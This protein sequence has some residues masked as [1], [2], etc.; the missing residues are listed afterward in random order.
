MKHDTY[1]ENGFYYSD[2]TKKHLVGY[3]DHYEFGKEI[4]IP[5]SVKTMSVYALNEFNAP[6]ST[7][8]LPQIKS[9]SPSFSNANI[10]KVVFKE[11]VREIPEKLFMD[12]NVKEVVLPSSLEIIGMQAFLR[13][14]TRKVNLE[15]VKSIEKEAFYNSDIEQVKLNKL[16][17][18]F[19]SIFRECKKLKE[20]ELNIKIVPPCTFLGCKKLKNV[21]LNN[22]TRISFDAFNDNISL[23][24]II[25]PPA[26]RTIEMSAFSGSGL[27]EIIIPKNVETISSY[28]FFV[29]KS[30]SKI[31]FEDGPLSLDIGSNVF[32]QSP[33]EIV[34][35]PKR[36]VRI[37]SNVLQDMPNL[38]TLYVHS[39]IEA[40][41]DG[42][43]TNC[44]K[45]ENIYLNPKIKS[46]GENSFKNCAI[47]EIGKQFKNIKEFGYACF[48]DC[49][50]LKNAFI[51]KG[52]KL[53]HYV[54]ASCE[55]LETVIFDNVFFTDKI[56]IFN[57]SNPVVYMSDKKELYDISETYDIKDLSEIP[58]EK[59][60][61]FVDLISY[62]NVS[63][64]F[65]PILFA[66]LT[67]RE[68][69]KL[70]K[71]R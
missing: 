11:G 63:E 59:L 45:L 17:S 42:F 70:E 27:E 69:Q 35:F 66:A 57:N 64:Q 25:F 5:D 8:F 65:E 48:S 58:T 36:A 68:I 53:S 52:S 1:V 38:K 28:A 19:Q 3:D 44:E 32:V 7:L 26:L 55:N 47:T 14:K 46:I 9:T 67:F 15:N 56:Y 61:D 22:T 20:A 43:A 4:V 33:A 49:S 54:F 50:K 18:N 10:K 23:K 21:K 31:E 71:T 62:K 12:S 41:E 24:H 30:L 13:S 40:I 37:G 2:W 6:D 60:K 16:E 34:S 51:G 39:D 29:S